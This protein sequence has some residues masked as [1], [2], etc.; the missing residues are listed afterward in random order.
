[1]TKTRLLV[2]VLSLMLLG[3][4]TV[5]AQKHYAVTSDRAIVVTREVLGNQGFEI[6]RVET[7]DHDRVVYYRRGNMGQG[8]GKGKL[9]K[10]VVRRVE[11][12]IVFVDTPEPFMVQIDLKLRM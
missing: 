11:N 7:H 3:A 2:G 4:S 8:K 1:M 5:S 9:E 10:M 6:V 12:R